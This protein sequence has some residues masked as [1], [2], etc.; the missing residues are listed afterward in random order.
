MI[1]LLRCASG[2]SLNVYFLYYLLRY[3]NYSFTFFQQLKLL[4]E[5]VHDIV[6]EPL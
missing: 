1:Q 3:K 5:M 2:I 6:L 4:E